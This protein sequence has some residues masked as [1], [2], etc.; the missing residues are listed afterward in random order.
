MP[1][2]LTHAV[3]GLGVGALLA[4]GPMPWPYHTLTLGLGL[5]PDLDVVAFPLGIPY[6]ARLGHRGLSHSV[7]LALLIGLLVALAASGL[8]GVVWWRLWPCFFAAL[9]SHPLLDALTDG[10]LG[11]ALFWP[12]DERR[13]FFPW[14]PICVSPIGLAGFS[15]RGLRALLSEML[16]VWLPLGL[17]VAVCLVVR[18]PF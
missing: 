3:A 10:G 7:L 17:A 2:V 16:W 4:P 14:R 8:L 11:V 5:L 9:A 12:F 13:Y 1:T 18:R 15:R 6:G